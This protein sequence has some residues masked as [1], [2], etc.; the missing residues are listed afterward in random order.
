VA[1]LIKLFSVA[2]SDTVDEEVARVL[3]SGQLA[4][5]P[6]V[7]EFERLLAPWTG[8][9]PVAVNSGTSALTLALRLANVGYGDEVISTPMTCSATNLPI[10]S[11]GASPVWAD[12]DPRTG[13]IDVMSIYRLITPRTKAIM[14]VDWGG[15]PVEYDWLARI[16]Q[17]ENIKVIIDAAHS[18]GATLRG[19]QATDFAD[20]V[21]FSFQAIK[22]LTTGD[23]GAIVCKTAIDTKRARRLRWFG[24]DRDVDVEFRGALDIEEWGYKFH[25]N[26]IAAAIGLA[27]LPGLAHTL[28]NHRAHAAVLDELLDERFTRT[29]PLYPHVGSWWLYTTLLPTRTDRDAFRHHCRE[30]R[31]QAS[32]VHWRNDSLT[33]FAAFKKSLPGVTE[34]ADRMI[35]LP[36]HS[37]ADPYVVAERANRFWS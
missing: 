14:A 27:N 29:T 37:G 17:E 12:V 8:G 15:Q 26:D 20:Y 24:I 9:Q 11:L 19:R 25:M 3:G 21:C 2:I 22:H 5:G 7:D 35:C 13:L 4:Q 10:L 31:L 23:G 6:R 34:F 30:V 33:A 32:Q 36:V 28:G 18:L 1:P 16:G